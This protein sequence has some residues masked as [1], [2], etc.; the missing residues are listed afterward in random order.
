MK[1]WSL[2]LAIAFAI[3]VGGFSTAALGSTADEA[4]MVRQVFEKYKQAVLSDNGE[5]AASL[6]SQGTID[7]YGDMQQLAVCASPQEVR[8]QS[9]VN[10]MQVLLLRWR[11]PPD[12]LPQMSELELVTYAV[13][14]GWI[15]K[16]GVVTVDIGDVTVSDSVALAQVLKNDQPS[17]I[18]FQFLKESGAWK[19][20]LQPLLQVSNLAF[21]ELAIL[22]EIEENEF[23]F[24][25]LESVEGRQPTE[26]IWQPV[27]PSA[28]MCE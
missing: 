1:N 21:K 17:R 16:S 27:F 2:R 14:Q 19:L 18:K 8:N 28:T 9:M 10:R 6:L 22:A 5:A 15:G 3:G 26:Q 4:Q 13:N 25:L 11:V 24:R 23:I 7:Y 20:D 12:V